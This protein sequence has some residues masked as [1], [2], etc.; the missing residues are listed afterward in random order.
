MDEPQK[1]EEHIDGHEEG[2]DEEVWNK[3]F[4]PVLV[5]LRLHEG[6]SGRTVKLDSPAAHSFDISKFSLTPLAQPRGFLRPGWRSK[7]DELG[8]A[9]IGGNLSHEEK[10]CRDGS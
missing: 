1:A 7:A 5:F 9:C 2:G 8:S 6:V 3:L 4:S 10:S